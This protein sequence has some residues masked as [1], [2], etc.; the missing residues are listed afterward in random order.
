MKM[1]LKICVRRPFA[2]VL[3][4]QNKMEWLFFEK[5]F[6]KAGDFISLTSRV[7]SS[8][9]TPSYQGTIHILSVEELLTVYGGRRVYKATYTIVT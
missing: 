4:N 3:L 2:D 7:S 9:I 1:L 8:D 5:S 6:C